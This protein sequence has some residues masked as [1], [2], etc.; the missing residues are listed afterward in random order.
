V[1]RAAE[2][3]AGATPVQGTPPLAR[4]PEE[5][6]IWLENSVAAGVPRER[7]AS[8]VVAGDP[9]LEI[10][11]AVDRLGADLVVMSRSEGHELR[12][13]VLGSVVAG[14]LRRAPCPVLVVPERHSA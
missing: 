14:V 2:I 3:V 12:R 8:E 11:G 13:A 10:L 6:G 1:R 5:E 4:A 9:T 7:A